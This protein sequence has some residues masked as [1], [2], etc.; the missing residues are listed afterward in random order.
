VQPNIHDDEKG[1]TQFL[2]LSRTHHVTPSGKDKTLLVFGVNNRP[3]ALTSALGCFDRF[4]MNLTS[5]ES[6]FMGESPLFLIEFQGHCKDDNVVQA[7]EA[8]KSH[9]TS[10]NVIGS[11]PIA[12]DP[13]K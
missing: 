13:R 3:V 10:L 12:V 2:V 1:V 7:L 9:T 5:I 4:Q 8:L 6:H 11:F